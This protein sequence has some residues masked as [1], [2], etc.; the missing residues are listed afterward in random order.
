MRY[1]HLRNWLELDPT[2]TGV[3]TIGL[4]FRSAPAPLVDAADEPIF[5]R[6][7]DSG[8]TRYN[9]YVHFNNTRQWADA[10]AAYNDWA[11]WLESKPDE[12]SDEIANQPLDTFVPTLAARIGMNRYAWNSID[13]RYDTFTGAPL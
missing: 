8:W 9:R 6:P 10:A 5:P 12:M 2:P 11:L 13:G 7:W 3:Y 4:Y 1:I